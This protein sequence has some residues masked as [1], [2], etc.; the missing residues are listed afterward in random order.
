MA[1]NA[2]YYQDSMDAV[3]ATAFILALAIARC[4]GSIYEIDELD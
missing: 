4:D 2:Y 1:G 3:L